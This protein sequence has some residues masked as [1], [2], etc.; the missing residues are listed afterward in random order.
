MIT[1]IPDVYFHRFHKRSGTIYVQMVV[2]F[3]KMQ[4]LFFVFYQF[5]TSVWIML[6]LESYVKN[7]LKTTFF[8]LNTGKNF[9]RGF[10]VKIGP[11][12][13]LLFEFYDIF[14][15]VKTSKFPCLMLVNLGFSQAFKRDLFEI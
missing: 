3:L 1:C 14:T 2:I 9:Q 13:P 4:F 7:S 15:G 8:D 5:F 12:L 11:H 10:I 6:Y